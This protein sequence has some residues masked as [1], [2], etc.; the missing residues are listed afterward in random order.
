MMKKALKR[1]V[2]AL[3]LIMIFT[4]PLWAGDK[5]GLRLITVT[6]EDEVQVASN[7]AILI[8]LCIFIC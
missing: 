5:L 6:G 8:L 2:L 1:V 3:V 4:A 7:Q